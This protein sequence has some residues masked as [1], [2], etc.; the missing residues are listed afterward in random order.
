MSGTSIARTNIFQSAVRQRDTSI[1]SLVVGARYHSTGWDRG[2]SL[3]ACFSI[4]ILNHYLRAYICWLYKFD[5]GLVNTS[6][7]YYLTYAAKPAQLVA[8]P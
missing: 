1:R 7:L 3:Q 8:I 6:A 2:G 5:L 4:A